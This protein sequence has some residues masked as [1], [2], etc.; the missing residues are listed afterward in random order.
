VVDLPAG[1]AGAHEESTASSP[2]L[3]PLAGA[4]TG[5]GA[6]S[7]ASS[8]RVV[9]DASNAKPVPGQPVDFTAH[10]A[11]AGAAQR[12][13]VEGAVFRVA[14]PGVAQGTQ[15]AASDDGSGAY[16]TTFAFLQAGRFEVSFAARV[17]GSAVRGVRVVVVQP[18]SAAATPAAPDAV[19]AREPPATPAPTS[20]PSAA[21]AASNKWL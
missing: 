9:I 4:R 18:A 19:P 2:S 20:P 10:V 5:Q 1:G 13:K 3:P 11:A 16:V 14:G 21:P 12:P 8:S 15:L 6:S 17:D 7:V